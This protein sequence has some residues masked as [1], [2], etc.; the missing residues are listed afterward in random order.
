MT[1]SS[2]MSQ[3]TLITKG[4]QGRLLQRFIRLGVEEEAPSSQ[5]PWRTLI[6]TFPFECLEE[7]PR[8]LSKNN[9][10]A[11]T[12]AKKFAA[13]FALITDTPV[14]LFYSGFGRS[15][16]FRCWHYPA[17]DFFMLRMLN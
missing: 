8:N 9:S 7:N 16:F 13:W 17:S 12:K 10:T 14:Q 6:L 5:K 4:S 15:H 2:I 11:A 3:R 1:S